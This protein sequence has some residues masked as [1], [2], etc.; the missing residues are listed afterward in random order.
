[1][2][3]NKQN[4]KPNNKLIT[5]ANKVVLNKSLASNSAKNIVPK[6][7]AYAFDD[8]PIKTIGIKYRLSWYWVA[9]KDG[10]MIL[11]PIIIIG[12]TKF[13]IINISLTATLYI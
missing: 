8:A 3:I 12:N 7:P 9:M 6:N 10:Y 5:P 4:K 1:M 13:S 11:I 2:R